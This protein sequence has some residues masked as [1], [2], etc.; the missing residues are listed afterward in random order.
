MA[1]RID[2]AE[3]R[4]PREFVVLLRRSAAQA[5]NGQADRLASLLDAYEI[6]PEELV[7]DLLR[8]CGLDLAEQDRWMRVYDELSQWD[9]LQP[10]TSAELDDRELLRARHARGGWLTRGRLVIGASVVVLGLVTWLFL[11]GGDNDPALISG[12]PGSPTPEASAIPSGAPSE[13]PSAAPDSSPTAPK[14]PVPKQLSGSITLANGQSADI[15]GG[16]ND[17]RWADGVLHSADNGKR[18]KLMPSGTTPS[19]QT[20]AALIPGQLSRS[21]GELSAGRSLCVRTNQ[22]RWARITVTSAGSSLG[23]NYVV[24]S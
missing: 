17:V 13:Q 3:A 4:T 16:G 21:V 9:G 5:H 15:D 24:F 8:P 6:P 20:C 12:P 10:L 22:N 23:F 7:T 19:A 18:L 11:S 1:G 14:S 2:P